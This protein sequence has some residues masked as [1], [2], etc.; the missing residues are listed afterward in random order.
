MH[1]DTSTVTITISTPEIIGKESSY[2][3]LHFMSLNVYFPAISSEKS[4]KYSGA[5]VWNGLPSFLKNIY[6][7]NVIEFKH[8]FIR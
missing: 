3:C 8:N 6:M 1:V 4:F 2:E 5:V 7:Q